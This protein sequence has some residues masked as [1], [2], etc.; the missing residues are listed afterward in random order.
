MNPFGRFPIP[1]AAQVGIAKF[2]ACPWQFF[3][4]VRDDEPDRLIWADFA[5]TRMMSS[6][7]RSDLIT[8]AIA[9][10]N[11]AGADG[12]LASIPRQYDLVLAAT[13]DP[14]VYQNVDLLFG[15][16]TGPRFRRSR[17]AKT[18][19]RKRSQCIPMLD[20]VVTSFLHGVCRH[21][22][23]S[24]ALAPSWFGA[25]WSSWTT[26]ISPYLRMIREDARHHQAE[27]EEL[28]RQIAADPFTGV[29]A[30]ASLLRIWEAT[31]FWAL[32]H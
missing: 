29:P 26:E 14:H 6:G 11:A 32:L 17:A 20:D 16:L 19:C 10:G 4:G 24:A 30:D 15:A 9:R 23:H 31:V 28:R 22:V 8:A 12:I 5:I 21:W 25:I 1:N 3:D 13:E 2:R 27:L 18:L 7:V